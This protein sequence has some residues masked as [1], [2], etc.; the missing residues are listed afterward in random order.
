MDDR[1]PHR[2]TPFTLHPR[3]SILALVLLCLAAEPV[4]SKSAGYFTDFHD[5]T[6]GKVPDDL[7]VL[8]GDFTIGE[9]HGKK[10]LE[11]PGE[12][13]DTFGCLFGPA[14]FTTGQVSAMIAGQSSGKRFPEF[15]VGSNDT[16]GFKIWLLP[17]Q[18][19]LELRKG[20]ET[21]ATATYS[22]RSAAWT[23]IEI[24]VERAGEKHWRVEG[25]AWPDGAAEPTQ[26]MLSIDE[27]EAPA[28][29]RASVWGAP[30]SGKPIRFTNL[31]VDQP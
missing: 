16:G 29:G 30:Y 24:R 1:A 8:N 19:R 11:V 26:W 15:G 7:M 23:H 12:P 27:T 10:F 17:G 28:P 6:A 4:T 21:K 3:S 9:D 31:A 20:D 2:S 14:D 22:W 5:S 13:L 25:K 18:S